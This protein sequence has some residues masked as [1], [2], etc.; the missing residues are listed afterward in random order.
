[1]TLTF[2]IVYFLYQQRSLFLWHHSIYCISTMAC[3]HWENWKT[4]VSP[5][6]LPQELFFLE[7]KEAFDFP[8]RW[9]YQQHREAH[10][11][12][13]YT[14]NTSNTYYTAVSPAP[15]KLA[16]LFYFETDAQ[17]GLWYAGDRLL[18]EERQKR[19][20][21]FHF[22]LRYR[23]FVIEAIHFHTPAGLQLP[24]CDGPSL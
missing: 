19:K 15:Q 12:P 18:W 14:P 20:P 3:T 11:P 22:A 2:F 8:Q 24:A 21:L 23:S 5:L 13:T 10:L 16:I 17:H 9:K 7:Q 4:L 6:L 1:M